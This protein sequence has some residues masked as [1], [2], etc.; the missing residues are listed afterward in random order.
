MGRAPR[1]GSSRG[2]SKPDGQGIKL[3]EGVIDL[4]FFMVAS[5]YFFTE[6]LF[7]VMPDEKDNTVETRLN[8]VVDGII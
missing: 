5:P 2:G 8:R 3:L 1:F 6:L 7:N 4:N